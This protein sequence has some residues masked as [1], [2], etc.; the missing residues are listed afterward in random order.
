[1][2]M[3]TPMVWFTIGRR[4][5]NSFS[6][7]TFLNRIRGRKAETDVNRAVSRRITPGSR[8]WLD[9]ANFVWRVSLFYPVEN[10]PVIRC[11]KFYANLIEIQVPFHPRPRAGIPY[12][13]RC[14]Y[15]N[16]GFLITSGTRRHLPKVY[17]HSYYLTAQGEGFM[18]REIRDT[19]TGR[20][21]VR[22]FGEADGKLISE[23]EQPSDYDPRSRPWFAPALAPDGVFWTQ[24]YV[25]FERQVVGITASIAR[26]VQGGPGQIVVSFGV[27]LDDLFREIQNMVPSANSRVFI[28][29]ND[30]RIY[31]PGGEGTPSVFRTT[32]EIGDPLIQKMVASWEERLLP[33]DEAFTLQHDQETWWCGFRSMED[34]NRHVW[35]GVMV[36]EADIMGRVDRRWKGLGALSSRRAGT[37][38]LGRRR[39]RASGR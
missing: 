18:A 9:K 20:K 15:R 22:R 28:F 38:G 8:H 14:D 31:V 27:L 5:N 1:M 21:A 13:D 10:S 36:P 19:G 25:F 30:A 29:R 12:A 33:K 34:A 23:E 39:H 37:S 26:E 17:R 16:R 24:P 3:P 35:V 4:L 7:I 11:Q 2:S 6:S 32:V